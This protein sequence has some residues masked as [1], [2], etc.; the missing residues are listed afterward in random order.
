M[1]KRK[2]QDILSYRI[3]NEPH[4]GKSHHYCPKCHHIIRPGQQSVA[5]Y[6]KKGNV[7]A[8]FCSNECQEGY[9]Q[10]ILTRIGF[11]ESP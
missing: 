11:Y 7:R 6:D 8:R 10:M 2:G 3:V 5:C 1:P 9:L 4:P